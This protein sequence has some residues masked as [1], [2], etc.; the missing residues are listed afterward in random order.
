MTK[1]GGHDKLFS[2][3]KAEFMQGVLPLV[4]QKLAADQKP[5]T[6]ENLKTYWQFPQIQLYLTQ[7]AE[8][9][10]WAC[11]Y[12]ALKQYLRTYP[13]LDNPDVLQWLYNIN[14]NYVGQYLKAK[15][16]M[17]VGGTVVK[18]IKEGTEITAQAIEPSPS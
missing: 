6:W 4:L 11:E 7:E 10:Q 18:L 12:K 5:I 3:R 14:A 9:P 15:T 13:K 2:E 16:E 17:E 1:A 8:H